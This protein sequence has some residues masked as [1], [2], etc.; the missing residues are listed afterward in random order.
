M[1]RPLRR[2]LRLAVVLATTVAAVNTISISA[3][4]ESRSG[5]QGGE[6]RHVHGL[7]INPGDGKVYVATHHGV[8]RI[9]APGKA[10][11]VG[12]GRQDTMGFTVIGE[13]TFLGSGHPA[14]GQ[15][16]PSNLGL[17]E[18]SD[19]AATWRTLSL[20]GEA[21]FHALEYAH[22]TVYGYDS[23]S[24]RLRVSADK[25]TWDNRAQLDAADIEVSPADRGI[26]L[27]TTEQ[28][29][30]RSTDGGRTFRPSG[31]VPQLLLS[32]PAAD[33]LYAVDPAGTL[34]RSADGGD[35]WK[36]ISTVPGG[37][38]QA[39]EAVDARHLLAATDGGIYE[40]RDGGATFTRLLP[41]S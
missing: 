10:A 39:F 24:Q 17:I 1:T 14:P 2:A 29:V 6:L 30:A 28:G 23:T 25:M 9:E 15:G 3:N 12:T 34:S 20:A 19:A 4:G 21:D 27:A 11:Q 35:I 22:G 13:N 40:S 5:G 18:S 8:Y 32:W 36:T 41:L 33:V 16:G 26:V 38:P 37:P 7:G 31:G